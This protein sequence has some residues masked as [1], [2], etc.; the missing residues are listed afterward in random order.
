MY[1]CRSMVRAAWSAS[2]TRLISAF[3]GVDSSR[4]PEWPGGCAATSAAASS[5]VCVV[6]ARSTGSAVAGAE[7]SGAG[8]AGTVGSGAVC[9]G[10][11]DCG[12]GCTGAVAGGAVCAAATAPVSSSA[13]R[14][15]FR[16]R[17]GMAA[18]PRAGC[19]QWNA[20]AVKR[21]SARDPASPV[22]A[23]RTPA[24]RVARDDRPSEGGPDVRRRRRPTLEIPPLPR[25]PGGGGAAAVP[26][27]AARRHRLRPHVR[28]PVDEFRVVA[29]RRRHGVR[30][31]GVGVRADRAVPPGPRRRDDGA[32]P[33]GAGD[34]RARPGRFVRARA[35]R[36][37]DDAGEPVAVRH[38]RRARGVGGVVGLRRPP[39]RSRAMTRPPTPRS[40]AMTRRSAPSPRAPGRRRVAAALAFAVALSACGGGADPDPAQYGARPALPGQET[41]LLPSMDIA[42]PAAWGDRL[43]AVPAGYGVAAIATDLLIPR[44]MLVLPNG[45]ILVAEG[46]GG[47]APKLR[48]KDVIAGKIKAKGNTSVD[49]GNRLTLLRDADGDGAYELNTVFAE[50]LNAPYGLA[51]VAGSLYVANQDALV[52]FAYVD[53]QTRADGDPETVVELPSAINHHWT[54][55]L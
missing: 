37:G 17:I 29:A 18:A 32:L 2:A 33:R 21:T 10:T 16:V 38:R 7:A 23:I 27:R 25:L 35:R 55:A 11:G 15:S 9:A 5:G 40:G 52:R 30:R 19:A 22:D 24:S 43:P 49:S 46:R 36:L 20:A 42:H 6:S 13:E 28:D 51:L 34:V 48:P 3:V 53:G 54:K 39:S 12:A 1:V 14:S 26:R 44:Q 47:N 4:K 50:D 8:S 31:R 45:D 41:R